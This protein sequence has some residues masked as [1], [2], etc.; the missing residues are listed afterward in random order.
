M[1]LSPSWEAI[2]QSVTQE[3]PNICR[4]W[5]F[6]TMYTK[7][8]HASLFWARWI[9][10]IPPHPI[11]LIY[12]NIILPP[13]SRSSFW[14]SHQNPICIPLSHILII[15]DKSCEDPHYATFSSLLL[16]HPSSS[17]YSPPEIPSICILPL[18]SKIKFHTH[19]RLLPKL[20]PL[21][22]KFLFLDSRQNN[23]IVTLIRGAI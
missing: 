17:K 23:I 6:T 20:Q 19:A 2:D 14:L 9:Q 5:R 16:F 21:K 18:M 3:F 10:S 1:E 4:T 8:H 12:F 22:F 13:M 15:L 7:A 11:R